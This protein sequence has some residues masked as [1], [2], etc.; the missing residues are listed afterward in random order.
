V[1]KGCASTSDAPG[2]FFRY[3]YGGVDFFF[4]D[5]RYYRSENTTE[6]GPGKT[7]LGRR[8][9]AWLKS[10]LERSR[11]PFKLLVSGSN[12]ALGQEPGSDT[13]AGFLHERNALF[14]TR[15]RLVSTGTAS[16]KARP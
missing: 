4:L 13:W 14:G 3:H 7:M 11:A 9:L 12:W 15:P 8:Q 2:V 6:D 16:A 5:C 1:P 10:E